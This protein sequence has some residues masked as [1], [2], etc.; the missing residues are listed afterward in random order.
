MITFSLWWMIVTHW[1]MSSSRHFSHSTPSLQWTSLSSVLTSGWN[2]SLYCRLQIPTRLSILCYDSSLMLLFPILLFLKWVSR[3][4]FII[5]FTSN[6]FRGSA[7][8]QEAASCSWS[9]CGGGWWGIGCDCWVSAAVAWEWSVWLYP[10]PFPSSSFSSIVYWLADTQF[11]QNPDTQ[12]SAWIQTESLL[13]ALRLLGAPYEADRNSVLQ[14][15]IE[16]DSNLDGECGLRL[17]FCRWISEHI[18]LVAQ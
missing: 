7:W 16:W 18:S 17:A 9:V 1:R 12:Q 2:S 15:G 14:V 6:V 3:C 5:E 11:V 13:Y 4:V 10:H 8:V